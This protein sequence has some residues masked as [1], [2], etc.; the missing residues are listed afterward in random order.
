MLFLLRQITLLFDIIGGGDQIQNGSIG[1][2]YR[3]PGFTEINI[4]Y[5]HRIIHMIQRSVN[6]VFIHS[7]I[8]EG[9]GS[10]GVP[11]SIKLQIL[12]PQALADHFQPLVYGSRKSVY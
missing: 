2:I 1:S 6:G 11:G 10:P 9:N 8:I 7:S 12:Y 5:F 3:I 4:R